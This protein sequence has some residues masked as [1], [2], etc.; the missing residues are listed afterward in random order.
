MR[1]F[2]AMWWSCTWTLSAKQT[3]L[4][5]ASSHLFWQTNVVRLKGKPQ[6]GGVSPA[7]R[8]GLLQHHAAC[9]MR[10]SRTCVA[11]RTFVVIRLDMFTSRFF[12]ISVVDHARRGFLPNTGNVF[13]TMSSCFYDCVNERSAKDA[14]PDIAGIGVSIYDPV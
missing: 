6:L 2:V 4:W 8:S 9:G 13:T 1:V 5:S 3:A 7:N 14:Y 12:L 11:T 10:L